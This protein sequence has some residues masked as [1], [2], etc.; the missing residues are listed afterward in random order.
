M[1]P[2]KL[3][4]R[5]KAHKCPHQKNKNKDKCKSVVEY[6]VKFGHI[7]KLYEIALKIYETD[8]NEIIENIRKGLN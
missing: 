7:E 2:E 4:R 8:M 5:H 1:W 3:P 6:A